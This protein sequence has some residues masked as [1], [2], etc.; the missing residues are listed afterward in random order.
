MA[1][2]VVDEAIRLPVKQRASDGT[3][4]YESLL[5]VPCGSRRYR[6]SKSP[7]MVENLAAGDVIELDENRPEG[8]RLLKRGGNVCVQVIRTEGISEFQTRLSEL[9]ESLGGWCDGATPQLIVFTIPVGVGLPR[10]KRS[11]TSASQSVQGQLGCI[12]TSTTLVAGP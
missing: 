2:L 1:P 10:L 11:S 7:G 3:I 6:L 4:V 5:A 12:I 9:V 8:Y